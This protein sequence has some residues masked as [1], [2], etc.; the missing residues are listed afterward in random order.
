MTS[1]LTLL[2][3]SLAA[4]GSTTTGSDD[5]HKAQVFQQATQAPEGS[6]GGACARAAWAERKAELRGAQAS[7]LHALA[8]CVNLDDPDEQWEC[9]LAA[10][11]DLEADKELAQERFLG[12]LELCMVLGEDTYL[13]DLDPD[14]FTSD[15][16]HP[17]FPLVPGTTRVYE[18]VTADGVE[19]I[20]VT[21]LEE[22][23]EILGVECRTVHDLVTLDG[24]VVEDTY[25]Y[26]AQDTS[27]NV[28]Y[29]G[30]MSFG[31]EGGYAV[32]MHGSWIAGVDDA[33]PGI[34]MLA[35]PASGVTYRQEFFLGEAE[36][37][38]SIL[39]VDGVAD[40][41]FGSF[42]ACVVTRDTTP[43]EPDV[44]EHKSYAAGIGAVLEVDMTD[45]S[46][47]ELID[48]IVE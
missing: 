25:D 41:P 19:E 8:V 20:R 48:V 2:T 3:L 14:D 12:R 29:F 36:D 44:L 18:K 6:D 15:V 10:F 39:A 4:F 32:D 33:Q 40:V 13:P 46:R 45:G 7:F 30:E 27:G 37:V 34:V 43:L 11:D 38:A 9:V 28:W 1:A 16:L 42:T 21:A 35:Q 47:L 24:E 26:Y 22:T 17:W 31:Y 23:R 5:A